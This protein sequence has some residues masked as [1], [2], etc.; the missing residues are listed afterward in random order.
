MSAPNVGKLSKSCKSANNNKRNEEIPPTPPNSADQDAERDTT[1]AEVKNRKPGRPP[2]AKPSSA[3]FQTYGIVAEPS[4]PDNIVEMVYENPKLFK[5][6][7]KLFKAHGIQ[8]MR[9][10]FKP[11]IVEISS[12]AYEKRVKIFVEINGKMLIRYYCKE[13]VSICVTHLELEKTFNKLEKTHT[14]TTLFMKASNCRSCLHIIV[15]D[16]EHGADSNNEVR[17]I[18]NNNISVP[19][20]NIPDE[21]SYPIR[22]HMNSKAWKNLIDDAVTNLK[23]NYITIDKSAV[24]DP[25]TISYGAPNGAPKTIAYRNPAKIGLVSLVDNDI[26]SCTINVGMLKPASKLNISDLVYL[27]ADSYND[28]CL[29]MLVDHKKYT[30]VG[31]Q[32]IEDN[33]C[34]VKIFTSIQKLCQF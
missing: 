27:S 22:F 15:H 2:K 13:E 21:A 24:D 8:E 33:V 25:L 1:K 30:S 23:S 17:L 5:N 11:N 18:A 4:E 31:N 16:S 14:Q 28:F 10:N 19:K 29:T 6:I 34:R 9:W 32:S 3:Q 26:F 12:Y 7:L 20:D